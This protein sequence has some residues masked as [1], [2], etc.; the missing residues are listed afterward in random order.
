[1]LTPAKPFIRVTKFLSAAAAVRTVLSQILKP[2]LSGQF[3]LDSIEITIIG[4]PSV[5]SKFTTESP[6]PKSQYKLMKV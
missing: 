2:L 6:D 4:S 3:S 5:S 1:M